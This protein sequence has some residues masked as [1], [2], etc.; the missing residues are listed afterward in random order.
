MAISLDPS[1]ADF[2]HNRAF[3]YRKKKN[4]EAAIED[5]TTAIDLD[6]KHFKAFYNR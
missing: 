1:K 3:A 2:Y 4:Y 6:P 5:Y